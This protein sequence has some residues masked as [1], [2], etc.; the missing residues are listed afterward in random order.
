MIKLKDFLI[1]LEEPERVFL[2]GDLVSGQLLVNLS[3]ETTFSNIKLQLVGKGE[4]HWTETVPVPLTSQVNISCLSENYP[5]SF[6]IYAMQHQIIDIY[7]DIRL[8]ILR[9]R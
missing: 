8:Y 2:P 4:V 3:E 6:Q 1:Q 5:I 9:I 7:L